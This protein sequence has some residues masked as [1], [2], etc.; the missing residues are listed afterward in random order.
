MATSSFTIQLKVDPSGA[1]SGTRVIKNQ[2]TQLSSQADKLRRT[3]SNML[4]GLGFALGVREIL[5]LSDSFLKLQNRLRVVT[6]SQ[7]ELRQVTDALYQ[8][9]RRTRSDFAATAELYSRVSLNAREL[10]VT[11]QQVLIFTERLNKAITVGGASAKEASAALIQLTQGL[12]SGVLRGDEL[13]SVLEQLPVVTDIIAKKLNVT[14]GELRLLG[15]EG[16]ISART[17]IDAFLEAGEDVDEA[18]ARTLP[19]ISQGFGQIRNAAVKL[20][21]DVEQTQSVF[22]SFAKVLV[23]VADNFENIARV[24]VI[25]ATAI[26]VN[27]AVKGVGAAITALNTFRIALLGNPLTFLP[28]AIGLAVGSLVAF[29]DKIKLSADS[30]A[31]L[32]DVFFSFLDTVQETIG[33][34]A[35]SLSK[36]FS[37]LGLDINLTLRDV[38]LGVA[39]VLDTVEGLL[40]VTVTT[41]WA[42]LQDGIPAVADLILK[43][44]RLVAKGIDA[45]INVFF[46]GTKALFQT[47]FNLMK[48]MVDVAVVTGEAISSALT[49]NFTQ[50]A[51]KLKKIENPF[52]GLTEKFAEDFKTNLKELQAKPQLADFIS[53]EG[54]DGA[55]AALGKRIGDN[56]AEGMQASPA[57]NFVLDVLNKAEERA[58]ARQR[59]KFVTNFA[60][61]PPKQPKRDP[62]FLKDLI[63]ENEL[64]KMNIGLLESQ[65]SVNTRIASIRKEAASS[66]KDLTL[67]EIALA[68]AILTQQEALKAQDSLLKEILGPQQT[69]KQ[70]IEALNRLYLDGEIVVSQYNAKLR[71]I[72]PPDTGGFLGQLQR[73]NDLIQQR[74]SLSAT[75]FV[76]EQQVF[77]VKEQRIQ[78]NEEFLATEEESIR[79]AYEH[80]VQLEAQ[81]ALYAEMTEPAELLRQKLEALQM[82]YVASN[83]ALAGYEEK[84]RELQIAQAELGTSVD[85]GL[86][87]GLLRAGQQLHDIAGLVSDT[88]VGAFQ[89]A[90]DALVEFA[91]TGKISFREFAQSIIAD[92]L[93][94]I[95]RMLLLQS[96]EALSGLPGLGALGKV[97]G[98]AAGGPVE[99]STP[100]IVGE[101]GPEL[102]V[103]EKAGNIIPADATAAALR[104]APSQQQAPVVN[105]MAAPAQVNVVNVSDPDEI[106]AAIQ[107]RAGEQ[108]VMNV[109]SK[110][111]GAIQR[112]S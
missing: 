40:R 8:S 103:P 60:P 58:Q 17:V 26:G 54:I 37:G 48:K 112:I 2:L 52:A 23:A 31:N 69:Q 101:K 63:L 64:I 81:A 32:A 94:I 41:L 110:N 72:K 7:G 84:L 49:G 79:K 39:A 87:A 99:K 98:K 86:T 77:N 71:E 82:L 105:V 61:P 95:S 21:G 53:I 6:R 59:D 97:A 28:A 102:F 35:D 90:E 46:A 27:F 106:P 51:D 15:Q 20:V 44:F 5:D 85:D 104:T 38:I 1:V 30:T 111:R 65:A 108:A 62:S 66:G 24:A 50:A 100:Y 47:L 68:S 76:V 91:T 75:E 4:T 16:K 96:I 34:T 45:S 42:L 83:G 73:E 107:S 43:V 57:V 89:K 67:Q 109:I 56:V 18:F 12:A 92:I 33:L 70:Q 36:L 19:T 80:R 55:A 93:R 14:R 13:R 74:L 78:Q 10:G 25:A 11:Q 9:V 22:S 3:F 88:V 29:A